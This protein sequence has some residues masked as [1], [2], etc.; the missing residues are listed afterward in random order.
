MHK[1]G[2]R[3]KKINLKEYRHIFNYVKPNK[4]VYFMIMALDCLTEISFYMLTPIV[5]K[6]MI[7]AA[8]KSSMELLKQGVVLTFTISGLGMLIFVIEEF[9]LFKIFETTTA[10]IRKRVF[11]HIL[12]LPAAFIEHN[13]S[14]DVIA[15]LTNDIPTMENAYKWPF[16]ML[17]VTLLSGLSSI[18]AMLLLDWK[19]SI[20]LILIGLISVIINFNQTNQLREINHSIQKMVG[21]Y[22]ENLSNVINGFVTIKSYQ[23]VKS[24]MDKTMRINEDILSAN[25]AVAKKNAFIESRNFLF[26][27]INFIG[28]I[29]LASF[30]ALKGIGNLGSVISMIFLLGNV[31]RMF[32]DING[33]LINLQSYMAGS[34]RV[35]TITGTDKETERI[36][37]TGTDD[38]DTMITMKEIEFSYASEDNNVLNKIN[39]KVKKGEIAALAGPSGGGKSTIIKLILGF[40]Q[41]NAGYMSINNRPLNSYTLEELR[42]LISYVPQDAYIFDTTI[43]ENIRYGKPDASLAEIKAAAKAAFA[44]EF[45]M[46]LS[47]GYATI[48]GERGI[49]LS[50]GQKQRIAIARAFLKDAPI[51]LLDEATSSLDSQSEQCIQDALNTLMKG[52]TSIIIAHRLSTIEHADVIYIVEEGKI[53]EC[54]KH[55]ELIMNGKLY[56]D[57]HKMQFIQE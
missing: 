53:V 49:K 13:H 46:E 50:G 7:D 6:L 20:L 3:M 17:I 40:Y 4:L 10:N 55:A 14:G 43:E 57:L 44:D 47:D 23:L 54:G 36:D 29:L 16:R 51:L 15:R 24:M 33:L 9:Y 25:L 5:M 35:S 11:D 41:P 37:I 30:L 42:A 56:Y 39:L 32:S 19:V 1:I 21:Q 48:V 45:I 26:G 8:V 18:A 34:A 31:N 38:I 12:H 28:V 27:S 2:V 52:K 22:T